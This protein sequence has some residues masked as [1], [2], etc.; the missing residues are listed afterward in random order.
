MVGVDGIGQPD[1]EELVPRPFLEA[2]NGGR[3]ARYRLT[4]VLRTDARDLGIVRLGT[5]DPA[6]FDDLDV[7]RARRA[8][9]DASR[10][11]EQALD[12]SEEM[13]APHGT[14]A[15]GDKQGVIIFDRDRRILVVTPVAQGLLGWR[16]EDVIGASCASVFNCTDEAGAPMCGACGLGRVFVRRE[17]T[18]P[19]A[20][21]M[22]TATGRREPLRV[23][24]WYLPPSGRIQEPRAMA[25]FRPDPLARTGPVIGPRVGKTSSP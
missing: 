9:A 15:A 19:A 1:F 17:V 20:M 8:A 25:V 13:E 11:F 24:F 18:E 3:P 12:R 4:L 14:T 5:L 22:A 2:L 6:G 23:S 21:R 7:A 16:P 10:D